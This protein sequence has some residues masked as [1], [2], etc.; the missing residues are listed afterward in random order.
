MRSLGG[1]E[2]EEAQEEKALADSGAK[3]TVREGERGG[4]AR[5]ETS[6]SKTFFQKN[7]P[8][9]SKG[10]ARTF[11]ELSKNFLRTF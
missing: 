6:F 3:S 7:F 4:R 11:Q 9:S 2:E 10:V 8:E 5:K 1:Q